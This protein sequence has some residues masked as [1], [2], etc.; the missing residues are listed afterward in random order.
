MSF[1]WKWGKQV[2]LT[3]EIKLTEL[4]TQVNTQR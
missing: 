1:D 2:Q 4:A 3:E